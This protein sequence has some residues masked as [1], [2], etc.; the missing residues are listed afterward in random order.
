MTKLI[1]LTLGEIPPLLREDSYRF[2]NLELSL[3]TTLELGTNP[4]YKFYIDDIFLGTRNFYKVYT[5]LG[6]YLLPRL[7]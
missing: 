5:F 3:L 7:L 2:I 1:Y 4:F 6:E